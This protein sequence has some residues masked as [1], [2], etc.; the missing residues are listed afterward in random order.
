MVG[1]ALWELEAR[2]APTP[3]PAPMGV[4][5][6]VSARLRVPARIGA[7]PRRGEGEGDAGIRRTDGRCGR[8]MWPGRR[9]TEGVADQGE[10]IGIAAAAE[11]ITDWPTAFLR[12]EPVPIKSP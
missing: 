7:G 4:R 3:R 8:S 2:P 11:Y 9:G 12:G 10:E 5:E 1:S 6:C